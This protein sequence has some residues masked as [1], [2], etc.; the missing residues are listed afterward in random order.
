MD[1][2]AGRDDPASTPAGPTAPAASTAPTPRVTRRS[3]LL[4]GAGIVMAAGAGAGVAGL[5]PRPAP[6]RAPQPPAILVQALAAERDLLAAVAATSAAHPE[7]GSLLT[8]L[9]GDH[10]D[11][12][13][14]FVTML[15]DYPGAATPTGVPTPPPPDTALGLRAVEQRAADAAAA[16]AA[17]LWGAEATLLASIAACEA[18]HAELLQ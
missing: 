14:A 2:P 15:A 8:Q 17:A 4:G 13:R 11:H 18:G 9:A 12:E 6:A 10:R 16:H 3:V 7:L 5:R 1:D